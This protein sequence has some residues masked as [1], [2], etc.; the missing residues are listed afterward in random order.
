MLQPH[1]FLVTLSLLLLT[2]CSL[3]RDRVE[4]VVQTEYIDRIIPKQ[5]RPRGIVTYPVKFFAVTEETFEDFKVRFED[6]YT[7]F[8]FFALSVPDYENLALNM[9]EIKRYIEQQTVLIVYYEDSIKPKENDD[10]TN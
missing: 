1:K 7:S 9:A 2:S 8:V 6:E 3:F 4:V 10:E 5:T